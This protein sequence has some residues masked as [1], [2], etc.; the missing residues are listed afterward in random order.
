ML[1]NLFIERGAV[2]A[3][4]ERG[5]KH[6]KETDAVRDDAKSRSWGHPRGCL[7]EVYTNFGEPLVKKT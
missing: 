7:R 3:T 5:R 6:G 1:S 4:S 2:Q